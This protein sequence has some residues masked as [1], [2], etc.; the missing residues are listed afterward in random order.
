MSKQSLLKAS[1]IFRQLVPT[2]TLLRQEFLFPSYT[3]GNWGLSGINSSQVGVRWSPEWLQC[4]K[5]DNSHCYFPFYDFLRIFSPKV[6][7]H[8]FLESHQEFEDSG[9]SEA[10][11]GTENPV[12]LLP[13]CNVSLS[14]GLSFP[15]DL[16][17]V[18]Q[19]DIIT[20]F[21][22]ISSCSEC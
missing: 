16:F 7:T 4:P 1:Q 10:V 19:I 12:P 9:Q 20:G 3:W 15:P 21:S 11:F 2:T 14:R 8:P 22:A 17:L 18:S 5:E 6:A 13:A